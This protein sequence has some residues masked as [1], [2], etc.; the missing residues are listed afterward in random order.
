M[1]IDDFDRGF[2]QGFESAEGLYKE[3]EEQ[4]LT[5]EDIKKMTTA[6]INEHWDEVAA[7][8]AGDDGE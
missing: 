3:D 4:P 5:R 7:V 8:L 2:T 1:S 6:Q